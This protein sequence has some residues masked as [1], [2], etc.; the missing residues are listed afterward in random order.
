MIRLST[1]CKCPTMNV[2][3]VSLILP[4]D[5][6]RRVL[7]IK[8]ASSILPWLFNVLAIIANTPPIPLLAPSTNLEFLGLVNPV[9]AFPASG[10]D[11]LI[12]R[13]FLIGFDLI[14]LF[15]PLNQFCLVAL[16]S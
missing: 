6:W 1:S 9:L 10:N 4:R 16:Y 2:A 8:L 15:E 14:G 3:S 13:R 11:N 5:N 12:L 7:A